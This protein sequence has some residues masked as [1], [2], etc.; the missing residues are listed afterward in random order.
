M[1]NCHGLPYLL[2]GTIAETGGNVCGFNV[3]MCKCENV[4]MK[5]SNWMCKLREG[6]VLP[7]KLTF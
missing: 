6:L 2:V 4:Q 7:T 1:N 3:Q 5:R